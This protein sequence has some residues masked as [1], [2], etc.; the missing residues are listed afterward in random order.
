M[1]C[2]VMKGNDIRLHGIIVTHPDGDHMNGIKKLLE[3]HGRNIFHKCDIVITKAFYWTSR[4]TPCEEFTK[5]IE[6]AYSAREYMY[7]E[8]ENLMCLTLGLNCHFPM[9]TGCLFSKRY[10]YDLKARHTQ[11]LE[12]FPKPKGV[13]ANETSILTVINESKGKCDVVLTGDSTAK[14]ILPLVGGK[15]IGIFQV[16]HHGSLHNSRL[17]KSH[18]VE[19]DSETKT[20]LLKIHD[21]E[22]QETFLFYNR[23]RARCYL[24]SAGG[25][26]NYKHPH[27]PVIQGIILAN[28][29]RH[30]ECVILLTNSHGLD[31]EKLGQLHQLVP[32]WT[33]YVKIYHYDDVFLSGQCHITLCPERCIGDVRTNTVEW[34]PKGYINRMKIMLPVK[35][36][37]SD[38]RPLEKNRFTEQSTVEITVKGILKFNAH[39]ICIPLPHSPRSGD[40]INCC[41][42]IEESIASGVDLSK[43]LFLL[44]GDTRL[45]LSRAKNYILIQYIN[46]EWQRKAVSATLEDI[47]PQTPPSECG[48]PHTDINSLWP[49]QESTPQSSLSRF[50]HQSPRPVP[51]TSPQTSQTRTPLYT[52]S[53]PQSSTRHTQQ[54]PQQCTSSLQLSNEGAQATASATHCFSQETKR[55]AGQQ[56]IGIVSPSPTQHHALHLL[57]QLELGS[58][59]KGCGCKKACVTRHCRCRKENRPCGPSCQCG[60]ECKNTHL[61]SQSAG[62]Q[63]KV[64]PGDK[65][66]VKLK[67]PTKGCGCTTG[68][69]KNIC[70]CKKQGLA[71]GSNCRCTNCKNN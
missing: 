65:A 21:K 3:K 69:V 62:P 66:E 9:E 46:D 52:G 7:I 1:E 4:D 13:D 34:T 12:T 54:P 49:A 55:T 10:V 56:S 31:S 67:S 35:P 37:M 59:I 5:L 30:Q 39:I 38:I 25:T 50:P 57:G 43:A 42:V 27:P 60:S 44:N 17:E 14:E 71:C 20:K 64:T 2:G 61:H 29:L 45:P 58:P 70:R 18:K 16:P 22:L 36:T 24:I 15:K 33:N 63:M 47:S 19:E 28:S 40:S 41:Y 51:D 48:I 26:A 8:G 68:C 53:S 23:F 11:Q 6:S 32:G